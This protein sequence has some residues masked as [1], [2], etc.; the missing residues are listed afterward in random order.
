[1]PLNTMLLTFY[2]Q[3]TLPHYYYITNMPPWEDS[4]MK[5]VE[6]LLS[7]MPQV[8]SG[9]PA[10]AD[11]QEESRLKALV[12]FRK[13]IAARWVYI[14]GLR[15]KVPDDH[16]KILVEKMMDSMLHLLEVHGAEVP[17]CPHPPESLTKTED[18]SEAKV[19]SS[20]VNAAASSTSTS[21]ST[22]SSML[23]HVFKFLQMSGE[24]SDVWTCVQ[25]WI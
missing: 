2:I 13:V 12:E 18:P 17:F 22:S 20:A 25:V 23:P 16:F 21:S 10:V 11:E 8:V 15:G 19:P 14:L 24:T 3:D 7:D 1:M 6:L 5:D 9:D 4:W